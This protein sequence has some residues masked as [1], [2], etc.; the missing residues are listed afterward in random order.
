MPITL[1]IS[2][3]CV[4]KKL[5]KTRCHISVFSRLRNQSHSYLDETRT[6][7]CIAFINY[8]HPLQRARTPVSIMFS[9]KQKY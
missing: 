9:I 2:R 4:Y 3:H 7:N 1:E 5:N 8:T 6:L